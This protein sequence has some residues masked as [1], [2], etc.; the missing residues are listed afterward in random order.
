MV[1]SVWQPFRLPMCVFVGAAGVRALARESW[2]MALQK[3]LGDV[4]MYGHALYVLN[5]QECLITIQRV[6]NHGLER[7]LLKGRWL[8]RFE[9]ALKPHK[10]AEH[11][12]ITRKYYR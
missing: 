10:A 2:K 3:K 8:V 7:D 6:E 4:G 12:S 11:S 1:S 5:S 9:P